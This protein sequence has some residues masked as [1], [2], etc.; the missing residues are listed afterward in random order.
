MDL[1]NP[2]QYRYTFYKDWFLGSLGK[3]VTL[4]QTPA[5]DFTLIAPQFDKDS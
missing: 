5:E 3:K 2:E 1:V 4:R